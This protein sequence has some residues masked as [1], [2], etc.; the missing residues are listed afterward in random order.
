MKVAIIGIGAVSQN[1][2]DSIILLKEKIVAICDI[3]PSKCEASQ[4]KFGYS[5]PIYTDYKEMLDKEDID[6][7]HICTPHYLH[8]EMICECLKRNINVLCEKPIAISYKQI[9][10]IE[11]AAQSSKAQLAICQQRRYEPA[12]QKIKEVLKDDEIYGANGCL[13]WRR[14]SNYYLH[15]VWRGKKKTEGGGVMINQALHT[16]D[17][18]NYLVGYPDSVIAHVSND[19]LK[20]VIDVEENAFGV[21][22]YK[23]GK[24]FTISATNANSV[25]NHVLIQ[26]VSKNH[27][28]QYVG[29]YLI[30]DGKLV[31]IK[32]NFVSSGK[33]E[34]GSGH[35]YII[36]DLYECIKENKKFP[37]DYKEGI[38]T[39]KLILAMYESKGKEIK[40]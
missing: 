40:L 25:S 32:N 27:N 16:L 19:T 3:V 4:K 10:Q 36:K 14:D 30:I 24:R 11:K 21:F 13:S 23:D 12:T 22:K 26:I 29:D 15:D 17:L 5:C 8:A 37:L 38:K 33:V 31:E 28:I 18:L 7:V 39:L 2:V 20:G 34:W 35:Y 6:V 9:E 1:H